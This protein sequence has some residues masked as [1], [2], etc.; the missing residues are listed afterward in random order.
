MLDDVQ[1]QHTDSTTYLGVTFDKRQ[2]WRNHIN[3]TEAKAR[4]KLALLR[5]LA[6]T[7]WGAAETVLKNVYIGAIRP[8]LEYGSTTFT[9]ASKSTLYML[10]KVQNQAMRLITG[11]MKSTPIKVMEE[12]TAISSLG[13]RRDMRNLIQA[14]RYKCSPSH[15][16]KVRING[17]TKNRIKRESII[18]KYQRLN[19]VFNN[20]IKFGKTMQSKF[21]SLPESFP[22]VNRSLTIRNTIQGLNKRQDDNI[23]KQQTLA[24]IDEHYPHELW[25]HV[26]TDGS[27][28]NA[29]QDGGAGSIIFLQGGQT[30]ENSTATGKHCTNYFAEVK[31]LEQGAKAV[32][33]LTDQTSDVVF[34]TD[35]R[36]ALDAIQNQNEPYLMRILN[37]SLEKRRVVLQW[38]PAQCGINGNEMAYKLAKRGAAMTQHDNPITLAE[39][40]TIIKHSFRAKK[41]PDNYHKLDRAEQVIILRLRKGHNR[42]N[43]HM[44]KTMKLVQSPLCTCYTGDHFADHILQD[45]PTFT[46]LRTQIW[47]DG[48][49]LHQQLHGTTEDMRRTVG[50][51]Q[52]TGL[53]V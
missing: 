4:R 53:S 15:P 44:Y 9:S 46:N 14:E 23:K 18:H 40:K 50:F 7:Q 37:G 29:V 43:S 27:A 20:S 5:K 34:L 17:M 36:S 16:M 28:T 8:H 10:D 25:I 12:T 30:I 41:I 45:C 47:P 52:Q 51:I 2:T 35:S 19:K 33:D 1:L 6:G 39:K 42:L 24:Y 21:S 3:S 22:Q 49:S 32:D 26:Y 11:A 13:Y 31:A 38:I 48:I